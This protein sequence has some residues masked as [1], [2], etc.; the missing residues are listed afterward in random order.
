MAT[1]GGEVPVILEKETIGFMKVFEY[2]K[3][4][5]STLVT[6]GFFGLIIYAISNGYAALDGHPVLL[7]I[8]FFSVVA[9][10]A[11]LE[12]LQV[13]I[14]A[15]IDAN[16]STFRHL[17]RA[18][19]NH[20]LANANHGLNVQ[21]FMVG[22]QFF[23]VFVVF[24]G[25]QL[26]TYSELK[27]DWLPN[28]L[29]I[30][31]IQTGMPG[32]LFV[33]SFGQLM[34]QLIA[35]THPVTFMNL[36]GSWAVIHMALGFEA[37]GVT[38]F[39]WVLSIMTKFVFNLNSPDIQTWTEEVSKLSR[40]SRVSK[41]SMVSGVSRSTKATEFQKFDS[42]INDESFTM[43]VNN[44][45]EGS[46][47]KCPENGEADTI[48]EHAE[49]M[50]WVQHASVKK[51]L[52]SWGQDT[53]LTKWPTEESIVRYLTSQGKEVPCYLLPCNHADYIP[54]HIVVME[55]ERKE[56]ERV[57]RCADP[58]YQCSYN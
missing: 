54:A 1:N 6:L 19:N 31:I 33:L 55:L 5:L 35:S 30:L 57:A 11:Y 34:P 49:G 45:N 29:Y 8:I 10:L 44:V 43:N 41:R 9:L 38:H 26:T 27:I 17:P 56:A 52:L 13:A 3:Y 40:R 37:A 22:R 16:R 53:Q 47:R 50:E 39:S 24:L 51:A 23:V 15:L 42:F 21:R 12:G 7:L 2:I 18:Y 46:L 20:K 25:A 32:V 14:M 28:F 4:V 58:N 48:S 36:P